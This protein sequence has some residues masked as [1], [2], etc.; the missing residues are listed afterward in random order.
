M[1]RHVV[2][3]IIIIIFVCFCGF[4]FIWRKMQSS[5]KKLLQNETNDKTSAKYSQNDY[6][7]KNVL[8]NVGL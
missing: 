1:I 3:I 5:Q 4:R 2:I 6:A 8:G 7:P